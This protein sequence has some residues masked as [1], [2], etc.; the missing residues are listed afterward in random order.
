VQEFSAHFMR[1]YNSIPTEVQP[2]PGAAQLRYTDSFDNDFTL[3]LRERRYANLDTMMS[4]TIK[5]EVNLMASGK[6][7]QSFNRGGKKPQGDAQ[8]STSRPSEDKFDLMMKTMEK[9]ME[10]MFMGNKPTAREQHDLQPRNQNL[11]RGLVP[12]IRQREQRDQGD[13]Q[14]RPPFQNN[15]ADEDFDQMI[16]DQMHCCDDK[17]TRVFLTKGEH[18]QYMRENDDIML[19]TDDTLSW[20]MEEFRKGYHNAIMQFQK[21]YNLRSRKASTEPQQ[22]NPIREPLAD[23]PSTSRPKKD[24]PTKDATEKGKSKEEVPRKAPETSRETG[25]KEVEK[26][27]P[28][29]NFENE[30]AKIKIS[31]P[32]NELIKKGE[33]RDQIIKMLKMGETPDTLNVQ[34]DHPAI[35]FGPRMEETGDT[36]DVP[37]FYVSLKVHDMTLHNAMLDSGARRTI[38]CPR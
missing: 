26:V 32:F 23:T 3:L 25:V 35:L 37:P 21:K 19:E 2:P 31:I 34:D 38:S 22:T 28:P 17:D 20:E 24:N 15:Y 29:F 4:D 12:Q 30:M 14:I 33:Y 13:Q 6:I 11:R 5:V 36:E 9:L 8:P 7:K 1:V 10:R 16:Q 27:S 18:D